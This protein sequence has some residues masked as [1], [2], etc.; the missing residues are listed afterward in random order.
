MQLTNR[1]DDYIAFKV[2]G[3]FFPHEEIQQF[4]FTEHRAWEFCKKK[5]EK[6]LMRFDALTLNLVKCCAP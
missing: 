2:T 6:K 5:K 1:T 3:I 4:G